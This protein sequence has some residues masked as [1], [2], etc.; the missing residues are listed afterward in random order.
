[1][2][3][4]AGAEHPREVGRDV[5]RGAE[6]A[7]DGVALDRAIRCD[8]HRVR[9]HL[10]VDPERVG[11]ATVERHDLADRV[12]KLVERAVVEARIGVRRPCNKQDKQGRLHRGPVQHGPC[13][14]QL[15]AVGRE[16]T[17]F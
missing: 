12:G 11:T 9:C 15:R 2:R 4:A 10:P 8:P 16:V 1:M 14:R 13:R 5:I 7:R 17:R 6:L 3:D